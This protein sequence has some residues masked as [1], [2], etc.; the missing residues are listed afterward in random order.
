MGVAYKPGLSNTDHLTVVS[1]P[2]ELAAVRKA[3]PTP[4]PYPGLWREFLVDL[5]S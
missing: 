1:R 2:L 5:A 4:N 3:M